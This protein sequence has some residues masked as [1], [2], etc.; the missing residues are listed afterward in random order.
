MVRGRTDLSA[1]Q[2][3]VAQRE[4]SSGNNSIEYSSQV[5]NYH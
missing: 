1:K 5:D 3:G 2:G 4:M